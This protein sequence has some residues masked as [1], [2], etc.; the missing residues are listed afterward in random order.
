MKRKLMTILL[1]CFT[2]AMSAQYVSIPVKYKGSSPNIGDFLTA[3]LSNV[4]NDGDACDSYFG[5]SQGDLEN[6]TKKQKTIKWK[7]NGF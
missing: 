7:G 1:T 3:L 6:G 4:D 5:E 2:L